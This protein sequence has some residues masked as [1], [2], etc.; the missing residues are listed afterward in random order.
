MRMGL[1]L[2]KKHSEDH[3]KKNEE[4]QSQVRQVC[5]LKCL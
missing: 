4:D 1:E 3:I 2:T 5:I